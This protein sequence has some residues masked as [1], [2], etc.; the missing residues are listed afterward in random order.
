MQKAKESLLLG[1]LLATAA[2]VQASCPGGLDPYDVLKSIYGYSELVFVGHAVKGPVGRR[3]QVEYSITSTWKGAQYERIWLDQFNHEDVRSG[4]RRL[5]FASRNE[6]SDDNS[7]H[8]NL[9]GSCMP[10]QFIP[11]VES[12][13]VEAYGE[14][15]VPD[16]TSRTRMGAILIATM[17]LGTVGMLASL[18][19]ASIINKGQW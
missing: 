19:N 3:G 5:I 8:D 2:N 1:A 11:D 9:R 16:T 17:L 6:Y 10:Y 4:E 7:W 12:M 18:W 14:P 13:L 15:V